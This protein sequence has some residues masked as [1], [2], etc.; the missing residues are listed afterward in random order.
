MKSRALLVTIALAGVAACGGKTTRTAAPHDRERISFQEI[1][2]LS[3][4]RTAYDVVQQLRPAWLSRRGQTSTRT[5]NP[6]IVYI[7]GA[8][9]G[10]VERL[11]DVLRSDVLEIRHLDSV[12]ATRVYG[13]GHSS[14]A[15]VVTLRSG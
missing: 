2:S 3:A 13:T 1:Q 6:V 7:G 14:G 12:N 10:G 11:Q 15:I 5:D 4:A 9:V 8:R